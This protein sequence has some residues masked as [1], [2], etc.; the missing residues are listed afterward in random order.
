[1]FWARVE[2]AGGRLFQTPMGNLSLIAD[3]PD[4]SFRPGEIFLGRFRIVRL[5][6]RGGMG[7]VFE[8]E[9]LQLGR[10]ALK[11]IRPDIAN[12]SHALDRFR[13]EV[14]LA[15]KVSG[16]QVCR[17]YELFLVPAGGHNA[18]TAFLTMEYL[19][20]VTLADK[21]KKSGPFSRQEGLALALDICEGLQSIHQQGIVHRDLKS[22][23]IMLCN[24]GGQMRAIVMDFGLAFDGLPD[25]RECNDST[26]SVALASTGSGV[27]AGTPAYMAPEQFEGKPVSAATDIYALGV[28]L[29][30]IFTGLQPYA[31]ATPVGAAIRRA[32]RPQPVSS[33]QRMPRHFDGVVERCLE[34]E[35]ERRYQSADQV[36]RALRAG[37]LDLHN[38]AVDRPWLVRAAVALLLVC[39]VWAVFSWWR[40]RQYYRPAAQA[41]RW[42][43]TGLASLREAS[44]LK[45]TRELGNA[46]AQDSRFVMAHAR[47]AEAWSNLDFDGAAQREMLT[48]SSGEDRIPPLDRMYLDAIRATLTRDFTGA[49]QLYQQIFDRLPESEKGAGYL[50]LGMAYERAGDPQRAQESY[51]Q[52][53]KLNPDNPAPYLRKGM[54]ESRQNQVDAANQ[55]LSRADALY[56][57]DMNPEGLAELDYQRGYLANQ[58]EANDEANNYLHRALS[59]AEHLPSVQLEIRALTQLSSVAYNSMRDPQAVE[60]AQKAI[61]LARDNQLDGWAAEGFVRMANADLDHAQDYPQADAA[62]AEAFRI[63]R[64]SQQSRV[65]AMANLTLA[66][67]RNQQQHPDDVLP[68]AVAALNYYKTNG[69]FHEA[70]RASL[71]IARAQRSRGELDQ[72]LQSGTE[73]AELAKKAGSQGLQTQAEELLGTV[74]LQLEDYPQAFD[75]FGQA[76]HLAG[77]GQ[78]KPWEALHEGE[79]YSRIGRYTDA[80]RMLAL[81]PAANPSVPEL[82]VGVLMGEGKFAQAEVLAAQLSRKSDLPPDDRFTVAVDG[83]LAEAFD[84][85]PKEALDHLQ[86]LSLLRNLTDDPAAVAARELGEAMVFFTAGDAQSAFGIAVK[87][88]A[89]FSANHRKDSGLRSALIAAQAARMRHDAVDESLFTKKSIDILTE[90]RNTWSPQLYLSYTSGP[91]LQF[92]GKG[93]VHPPK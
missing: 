88:E 61:Q 79:I 64:Q 46:T 1:L 85:R 68:P 93:I 76:F 71:L 6:G 14:Q 16:Q 10:I 49:L 58:R 38:L 87:A 74:Y 5:L 23:N 4:R 56:T 32:K 31:A 91:D 42:Y 41:E 36:V 26:A 66:S 53:S 52:A 75:R 15:R 18:A 34:Y 89:W 3:E 35:Q 82:Q 27:I 65:E 25:V 62:L 44:Y 84:R 7:E 11:T 45:A 40:T 9:D 17:I 22:A 39:A 63:L 21:L 77:D 37:P 12:S 67:L 30:E 92:L 60:L 8:A 20:G 24:R 72:A 86:N 55:D 33:M 48:A 47:L 19:D 13:R 28:V 57:S 83:A 50:D 29:Y 73:L 43:E 59:E 78:L 69:H 2:Y 90:L 51:I 70:A 81:A 80:E 54:L